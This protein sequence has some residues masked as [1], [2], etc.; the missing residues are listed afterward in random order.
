M[1]SGA[2]LQGA[3]DAVAAEVLDDL[4]AV[5]AGGAFDGGA[6]A[7][8]G[9]AGA[10]AAW[11]PAGPGGG[12]AEAG[13]TGGCR[14]ARRG[15]AGVGKVAVQLGRDVDVEHIAR[16]R[17]TRSTG[18]AVSGFFVDADARGAGE[19]VGELGLIGR[20]VNSRAAPRASS[21]RV[22][23]PGRA[24]SSISCSTRDTMRPMR[25]RAVMS[26]SVS[27]VMGGSWMGWCQLTLAKVP[28]K[29]ATSVTRWSR[30]RQSRRPG[31]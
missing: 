11:R 10:G 4:E 22:L 5:G 13:L 12:M 7:A 3:A 26:S 17:M 15:A 8:N 18:D 27:M 14:A 28:A 9:H 30:P 20:R 23:M 19:V 6:N 16:A 29:M 21:S 31:T 1:C 2:S 25:L 24:V